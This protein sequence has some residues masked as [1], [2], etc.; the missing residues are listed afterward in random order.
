MLL[1]S[2]VVAS[3]L[4]LTVSVACAGPDSTHDETGPDIAGIT[5]P[6]THAAEADFLYHRFNQRLL[7]YDFAQHRVEEISDAPNYFQYEFPTPSRLYTVGDS[8]KGG[9]S[10]IDVHDR[11]ITE[12]LAMPQDRGIFPLATSGQTSFF[13]RTAYDEQGQETDREL[14]R[15]DAGHEL[16][17]FTKVSG[18]VDSGAIVEGRLHFSV[19]DER[20]DSYDVWSVPVDDPAAEPRR[21]LTDLASGRLYA[22]D[23]ELWHADATSIVRDGRSFECADLCYFHD[24]ESILVRIRV[25]QDSDLD[26]D[27]IDTRTGDVIGSIGDGVDYRVADGAVT[28]FREGDV[29]RVDL[30][31]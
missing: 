11:E 19:F 21:E 16:V 24:A 29:K 5:L 10:I 27:V 13:L 20:S 30:R 26:L 15:L 2:T 9:Y 3:V 17:P 28:V 18:L 22:H 31:R 1:R 7:S 4:C 23:G 14:V 25:G 8:V 12:L 6:R